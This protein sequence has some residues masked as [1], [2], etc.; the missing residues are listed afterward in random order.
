MQVKS[1][2]KTVSFHTT[3]LAQSRRVLHSAAAAKRN[4]LGS[5]LTPPQATTLYNGVLCLLPHV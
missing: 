1:V 4:L 2:T 5:L 3:S